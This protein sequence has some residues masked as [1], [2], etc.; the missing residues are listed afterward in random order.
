MISG[1]PSMVSSSSSSSS[2]PH[3]PIL[4]HPPTFSTTTT[5][6]TAT[7]SVPPSQ[8]TFGRMS[9]PLHHHHHHHHSTM[10]IAATTTMTTP[11]N[12]GNLLNSLVP[13][14]SELMIASPFFQ[15][16]SRVWYVND[17]STA[18]ENDHD[19]HDNHDDQH[20]PPHS[21][22]SSSSSQEETMKL[23]ELFTQVNYDVI[24]LATNNPSFTLLLTARGSVLAKVHPLPSSSS[25]SSSSSSLPEGFPFT[26]CAICSSSTLP[27]FTTSA[28][29]SMCFSSGEHATEAGTN[30]EVMIP[31][32]SG[33][34]TIPSSQLAQPCLIPALQFER[35]L[36]DKRFVAIANGHCF[37]V[38][39]A[40][41][42]EMYTWGVGTKGELGLGEIVETSHPYLCTKLT[43]YHV[44]QVACGSHHGVALDDQG[45]VFAWGDN[46]FG[47]LGSNNTTWRAE[48]ARVTQLDRIFIRS[49]AA[50]AD[51]TLC[52]DIK[53]RVFAFGKNEQGQCGCMAG[54][55]RLVPTT[56]RQFP[57]EVVQIACGLSHSIAL[58]ANGEV[59]VWGC[60]AFGECGVDYTVAFATSPQQVPLS[61]I[62]HHD[63]V[64]T[65]VR[66]GGHRC[67]VVTNE[68]RVI[69]WGEH[70]G[71][72]PQVCPA[73]L[74]LQ[75]QSHG[76]DR[77]I[78]KRQEASTSEMITITDI[79]ISDSSFF[80][81][82][83]NQQGGMSTDSL[84]PVQDLLGMEEEEEEVPSAKQV[85]RSWRL[86]TRR[87]PK[88]STNEVRQKQIRSISAKW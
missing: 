40:A 20:Q 47:Q 56:V 64:V 16:R 72:Q 62:L 44:I 12:D 28:V 17:E 2:D 43:E 3:P 81:I 6:T 79:I 45:H 5:T 10:M 53:G 52:L 37:S 59:V 13:R 70:C 75:S 63:E 26:T 29:S 41:S 21:S 82:Q 77:E 80:L 49:I 38:A 15:K 83:D 68:G 51:F 31:L 88:R 65:T 74:L 1:L 87:N 22:S 7:S 66:A 30:E 84:S 39:L 78:P 25:S 76:E 55:P 11:S 67:A 34:D 36:R 60:G 48:P 71:N 19:N 9:Q 69:M 42:G 24:S 4:S 32:A 50:G 61:R 85:R 27:A 46:T 14:D 73:Q 18:H 33:L 8:P 86:S 54:V 23:E 58:C 57:G 35:A